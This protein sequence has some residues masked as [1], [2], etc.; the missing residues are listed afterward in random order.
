MMFFGL[1]N[2]VLMGKFGI[3]SL[4][5]CIIVL[6]FCG[7]KNNVYLELEVFIGKEIIFFDKNFNMVGNKV[8]KD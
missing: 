1:V 3:F 8:F 5:F 7:K 2:E 4:M 6:L